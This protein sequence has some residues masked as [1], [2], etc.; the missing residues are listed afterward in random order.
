MQGTPHNVDDVPPGREPKPK[1]GAGEE[2]HRKGEEEPPRG[3]TGNGEPDPDV[4]GPTPDSERQRDE[5]RTESV[6]K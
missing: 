4:E 2:P 6:V 3:T 5:M 1:P